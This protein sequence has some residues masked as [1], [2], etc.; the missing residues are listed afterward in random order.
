MYISNSKKDNYKM[1]RLEERLKQE[2]TNHKNMKIERAKIS[3]TL[4]NQQIAKSAQKQKIN[5]TLFQMAVWNH[6]DENL[7]LNI[8]QKEG[9]ENTRNIGLN[10]ILRAKHRNKSNMEKKGGIDS[11]A[12]INKEISRNKQNLKSNTVE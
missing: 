12:E 6:F 11:L 5:D 10:E 1:Q 8:L 4:T 9:K 2:E 3:N 7:I